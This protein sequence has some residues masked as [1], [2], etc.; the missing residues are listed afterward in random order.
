MTGRRWSSSFNG[1]RAARGGS[2]PRG[3]LAIPSYG[4]EIMRTILR[5]SFRPCRALFGAALVL[6]PAIGCDRGATGPDGSALSATEANDWASALD[7]YGALVMSSQAVEAERAGSSSGARTVEITFKERQM[8]PAGGEMRLEGRIVREYTRETRT[9][10][11]RGEATQ[12]L[13]ACARTGERGS[14]LTVDGEMTLSAEHRWVEGRPN[15]PQTQ[16]LIGTLKW[17]HSSGQ[18]RSCE[19]RTTAVHDPEKRTRTMTG[20]V[21]GREVE[22]TVSWGAS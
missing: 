11:A 18:T 4:T 15:G 19:Y 5:V 1:S 16:S 3:R 21:C 8:C 14:T 22:R 10:T 9:A 12:T 6:V 2:A 17:T 20:T 13:A 7:G